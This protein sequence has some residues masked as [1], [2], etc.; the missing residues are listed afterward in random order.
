MTSWQL[1][2]FSSIIVE[3]HFVLRHHKESIP[4]KP[5]KLCDVKDKRWL[6]SQTPGFRVLIFMCARHEFTLFKVQ[7]VN[8]NI[9]NISF[10]TAVHID[11]KC[12]GA[13]KK[14]KEEIV[15]LIIFDTFFIEVLIMAFI[16]IKSFTNR[17]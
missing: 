5:L 10:F 7:Q 14:Q 12:G 2:F 15:C 8:I 16:S 9:L 1:V 17:S 13:C 4:Q 6:W 11:A 3:I